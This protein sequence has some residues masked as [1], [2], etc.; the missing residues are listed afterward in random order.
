[1]N[2]Y[3]VNYHDA[4][5]ALSRNNRPSFY[6]ECGGYAEKRWLEKLASLRPHEDDGMAPVAGPR[7]ELATTSAAMYFAAI[8]RWKPVAIGDL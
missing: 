4:V 5:V 1:M 6:R 3:L 2:K 8:R 7:D